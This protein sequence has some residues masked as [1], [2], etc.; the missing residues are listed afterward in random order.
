MSI[1]ITDDKHYKDIADKIRENSYSSELMKPSEIPGKIEAVYR[2]GRIDGETEA[3]A[4]GWDDGK[5]A[6]YDAFW[7]AYQ[8]YGEPKPYTNAFGSMWTAELF[9][10]KYDIRPTNAYMMFHNNIGTS[11]IIDDFVDF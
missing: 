4:L 6:E 2:T 1:V 8:S 11:I 10:P 7:D 3:Y 5:Q 9:K